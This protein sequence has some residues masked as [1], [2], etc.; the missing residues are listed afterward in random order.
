ME[1][2]RRPIAPDY[3][4]NL[5]RTASLTNVNLQ[6]EKSLTTLNKFSS[7]PGSTASAFCL[8]SLCEMFSFFRKVSSVPKRK[9]KAV[10]VI[11]ILFLTHLFML[12]YLH[13]SFFALFGPL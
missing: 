8:Y 11:L 5:Y 6:T 12:L 3:H 2:Q 10:N 7:E 9:K 13:F 4:R 1:R